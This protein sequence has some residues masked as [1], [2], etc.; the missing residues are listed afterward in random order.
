MEKIISKSNSNVKF[1]SGLNEKK[2]RQKNNAFYLEGIK[3]VNELLDKAIDIMFIAYSKSI[4]ASSNGG[5]ELINRLENQAKVKVLEFDDKIF[6]YVTDTVNP[7][8]VLAVLKIPEYSLEKEI[9]NT[10]NNILILDKVQDQGNLGTIIRSANAFN[11]DLII[12]TQG[13]ADVYSPKTLRSTM[14]GILNTKIIYIDDINALKE[15]KENGFKI[16]TTSLNTN[17]SSDTLDYLNNKYAFVVGNEA[18]GVS[19][20]VELLSDEL[21]KIPMSDRIES[22]NVGV[23]TSIILYEQYKAKNIKK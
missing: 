3:V 17:N 4:L 14:G 22:L 6:K 2:F 5:E 7:Q 10:K 19:K 1:V 9:S 21:V 12:C 11:I 15:L 18:N 8:G 20:E 23:A 16:V 13:T